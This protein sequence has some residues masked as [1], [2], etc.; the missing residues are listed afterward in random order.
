MRNPHPTDFKPTYDSIIAPAVAMFE[1]ETAQQRYVPLAQ[2]YPGAG[3][4]VDDYT[5]LV[6]AEDG[7]LDFRYIHVGNWA[8]RMVGEAAEGRLVTDVIPAAEAQDAL[9]SYSHVVIK[10]EPVIEERRLMFRGF[11]PFRYHRAMLPLSADGGAVT[12]VLVYV[13]PGLWWAQKPL[14]LKQRQQG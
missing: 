6:E 13:A 14:D 10:N 9:F 5:V 2:F 7:L 12:H 11:V 3:G 1:A 4:P 8:R